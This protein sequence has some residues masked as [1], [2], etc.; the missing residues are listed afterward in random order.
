MKKFIISLL[1][2]LSVLGISSLEAKEYIIRAG[3]QYADGTAYNAL[4]WFGGTKL[5]F[6]ASFDESAVYSLPSHEQSDMNKLYGFSDC[7]AHHYQSSARFGWRWYK[8]QIQI[9]GISHYDGTWHLTQVLGVADFHKVYKFKIELSIDG[10]NYLFSFNNQTPVAI[11]RHC[12]DRSMFGYYLYPYF[13]GNM[14]APHN[15]RISIWEQERANFVVEKAYPNP[16]P[17][18]KPLNL[19]L[20]IGERQDIRFDVY[21]VTGSLVHTE[22]ITDLIP[23]DEPQKIELNIPSYLSSGMYLIQPVSL[24]GSSPLPGYVAAG[25][26]NAIKIIFLK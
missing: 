24:S 5:E 9:L 21:S 4:R 17:A 16:L 14:Q 26:G 6:K 13:G 7:K 1:S 3:N 2:L 15:V 11:T 20:L 8:N 19:S 12:Q 25:S 23:N 22:T 18:D 10:A